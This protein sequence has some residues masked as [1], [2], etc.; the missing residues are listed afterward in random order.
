DGDEDTGGFRAERHGQRSMAC[1]EEKDDYGSTR[2]SVP[3]RSPFNVRRL[4]PVERA[5]VRGIGDVAA[6]SPAP[7]RGRR[8]EI[9]LARYS[10][11]PDTTRRYFKRGCRALN[12]LRP[13]RWA[14][15][16]LGCTQSSDSH[17]AEL[18]QRSA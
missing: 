14:P 8:S 2:R 11:L 9:R 6:F 10:W 15:A 1:I 3:F 5:S 12:Q 16:S 7:R 18:V 17:G 4:P 13:M